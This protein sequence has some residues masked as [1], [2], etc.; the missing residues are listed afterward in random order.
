MGREDWSQGFPQ[1]RESA[2]PSWEPS[3]ERDWRREQEYGPEE[4]IY[5]QD[6][7]GQ[8]MSGYEDS[9]G[10]SSEYRAGPDWFSR[11][12]DPYRRE[13]W[14][15]R[16]RASGYRLQPGYPGGSLQYRRGTSQTSFAGRGPQGYRRSDD[17]ISEDINEM[18]TQ[19][20]EIDASNITVEVHNGEVTLKGSVSNRQA[21][22]RSEDIA[23]SC[24]GV[25]DV[26]N[27]LRIRRE[28]ESES[29]SR[30]EK[31]EEKQRSPRIAS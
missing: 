16:G 25:K 23:E 17:R 18:L 8:G 11:S 7:Y 14:G 24:S 1:Y 9:E 5:A 13:G 19:D 28:E 20:P 26:Q 6:E 21:K 29:E 12:Q 10:E 4:W 3:R 22:R 2:R 31:G 15:Q 30:R 27:L